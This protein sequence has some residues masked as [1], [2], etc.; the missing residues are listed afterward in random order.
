MSELTAALDRL[1]VGKRGPKATRLRQSLLQGLPADVCWP[2][3]G[4]T[5]SNGYGLAI[6]PGTHNQGTTAH[7]L[8]YEVLVGEIPE[9]YTVDHICH[10]PETCKL[11]T[12]CPHRRCVNPAHLKAVTARE[13]TRRSNSAAARNARKTACDR[14]H[15]YTPENT[16]IYP[17]GG[18]A[19]RTCQ[20][21]HWRRYAAEKRSA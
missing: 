19:C 2:W 9:G 11:A 12:D 18:R 16:Y 17:S 15:A 3:L 20:R 7:R 10:D 4:R 6:R 21:A 1:P 5:G 14:G 8:V 13:N